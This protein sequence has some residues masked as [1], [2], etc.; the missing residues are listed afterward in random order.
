MR[1][2]SSPLLFTYRSRYDASFCLQK[3]TQIRRLED[4]DCCRSGERHNLNSESKDAFKDA[5][6]K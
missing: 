5:S 6:C 4:G 3:A 2:Q 1:Y